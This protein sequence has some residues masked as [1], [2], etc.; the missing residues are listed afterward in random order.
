MIQTEE[1]DLIYLFCF[2]S[3]LPLAPARV[4]NNSAVQFERCFVRK[5]LFGANK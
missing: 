1:I 4:P 2:T 3:P 5:R